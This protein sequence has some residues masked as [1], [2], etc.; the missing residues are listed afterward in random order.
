MTRRGI[1]QPGERFVPAKRLHHLENRRRD[2]DADEGRAQRLRHRAELQAPAVD[3]A[4]HD[5]FEGRRRP[6]GLGE[7]L[8]QIAQQPGRRAG[9]QRLGLVVER[10]R[11]SVV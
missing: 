11:K 4:A 6:R 7:C 3:E 2:G 9:E 1:G 8:R 10:D 5:I